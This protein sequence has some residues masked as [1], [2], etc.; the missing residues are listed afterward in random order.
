[1]DEY[2]NKLKSDQEQ[3]KLA[4]SKTN[5]NEGSHLTT[6]HSTHLN[7]RADTDFDQSVD[8]GYDKKTSSIAD[9]NRLHTSSSKGMSIGG[10]V[11]K[12]MKEFMKSQLSK[13]KQTGENAV[14][15]ICKF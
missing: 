8:S 7:D 4:S 6:D 1:M 13:T 10:K 9:K 15:M 14:M 12:N 5:N 11:P 3:A 2:L